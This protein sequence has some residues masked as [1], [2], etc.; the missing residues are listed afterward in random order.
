MNGP[1]KAPGEM[2]ISIWRILGLLRPKE[3]I[4][5]QQLMS[6]LEMVGSRPFTYQ[7]VK[8]FKT[9]YAPV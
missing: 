1:V 6:K 5:L 9:G 7:L 8:D 2:V 3:K 4:N